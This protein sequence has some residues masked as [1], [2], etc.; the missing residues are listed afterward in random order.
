MSAVH[1]SVPSAVS[2][3]TH[4]K[5]DAAS[6]SSAVDAV[7]DGVAEKQDETI[8]VRDVHSGGT[9]VR[10]RLVVIVGSP[11]TVSVGLPVT[12]LSSPVKVS[13]AAAP[14]PQVGTSARQALASPPSS[15]LE[16]SISGKHRS[17]SPSS[18]KERTY[19]ST[20]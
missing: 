8:A 13:E 10:L 7:S 20:G 5:Q 12:E 16:F 6:L 11:V 1:P 2:S 18:S 15:V 17:P 14:T 19:R 9:V 4:H 3:T